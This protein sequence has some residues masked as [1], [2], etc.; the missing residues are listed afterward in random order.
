MAALSL[1]LAGCLTL[2]GR[3]VRGWSRALAGPDSAAA[4]AQLSG[5]PEAARLALRLLRSEHAAVVAGAQE[6][7]RSLG[8]DAPVTSLYRLSRYSGPEAPP[9]RAREAACALL[10]D[11]T[12]DPEMLVSALV[13]ADPRTRA[14]VADALTEVGDAAVVPLVAALSDSTRAA[15]AGRTRARL[16][17]PAV[18]VSLAIAAR[19]PLPSSAQGASFAINGLLARSRARELAPGDRGVDLQGYAFYA[20]DP[21]DTALRAFEVYCPILQVSPRSPNHDSRAVKL[22]AHALSPLATPAELCGAWAAGEAETRLD[23]VLRVA[24]GIQKPDDIPFFAE[25]AVV[26]ADVNL[27][28]EAATALA[29][30]AEDDQLAKDALQAALSRPEGKIVAAALV[31]FS[32]ADGDRESLDGLIAALGSSS[33]YARKRAQRA[34]PSWGRQG[35][36]AVVKATRAPATRPGAIAALGGFGS[37]AAPLLVEALRDPDARVRVAALTALRRL[38]TV[39]QSPGDMPEE[40]VWKE[41]AA[42]VRETLREPL[43]ATAADPDAG[44]RLEAASAIPLYFPPRYRRSPVDDPPAPL[45][46]A[47][48][49]CPPAPWTAPVFEALWTLAGDPVPGVAQRASAFLAVTGLRRGECVVVPGVPARKPPAGAR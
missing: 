19:P 48:P 9:Q 46:P 49:A 43:L 2:D 20:V 21:R 26:D 12:A 39:T 11:L 15:A 10:P 14:R 24:A 8:D 36:D 47:S 13:A 5:R 44:V 28:A 45:A 23:T 38:P 18:G 3:S 29:L 40:T 7:L 1:V 16:G 27:A 32:T 6:T 42:W 4:V 33:V 35:Y 34:L 17:P 31:A 37:V 22:A 25:I 30:V 41:A